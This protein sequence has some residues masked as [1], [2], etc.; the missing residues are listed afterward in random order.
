[1]RNSFFAIALGLF[2]LSCNYDRSSNGNIDQAYAKEDYASVH[3]QHKKEMRDRQKAATQSKDKLSKQAEIKDT[4]AV[5]KPDSN[6]SAHQEE[7]HH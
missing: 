2:I 6:A 4:A 3:G 7:A 5:A 1:M